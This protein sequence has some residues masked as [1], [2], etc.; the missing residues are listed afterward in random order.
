MNDK[1]TLLILLALLLG[2]FVILGAVLL[3]SNGSAISGQSGSSQIE[4]SSSSV[5]LI[6]KRPESIKTAA[7]KT[8]TQTY[9]LSRGGDGRLI[10]DGLNGLLQSE[11]ALNAA[12]S[13]MAFIQADEKIIDNAE[14]L[15][16]YGF[17]N[18][19]SFRIT[20]DDG[21]IFTFEAGGEAPLGGTY[22]RVN[23]ENTVYL[24]KDGVSGLFPDRESFVEKNLISD[25]TY[26]DENTGKIVV[27]N[28]E[29]IV[30]SGAIRENEIILSDNPDPDPDSGAF[31]SSHTIETYYDMPC[32][33][34]IMSEIMSSLLPFSADTA[35]FANPDED[36]LERYGLNR[37]RSV[38]MFEV[39]G[40]KH[41]IRLGNKNNDS[42]FCTV[43]DVPCLFLVNSI[44][45]PWAELSE[46]QLIGDPAF[47]PKETQI[48]NITFD[49]GSE[50]DVYALT[51]GKVGDENSVTA[52]RLNGKDCPVDNYKNI[53][54]A[55]LDALKP[56]QKGEA[57]YGE[58]RLLTVEY[59]YFAS[60]K[61]DVLDFYEADA[62]TCR[63]VINGQAEVFVSADRVKS[64]IS[65]IGIE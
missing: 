24:I 31:Y 29:N 37:P 22:V 61:I 13:A 44:N 60:D 64:V 23:G 7:V 30:L 38:I 34:N 15:S 56:V 35:V 63:L 59:G 48:S 58:R 5:T 14:N 36:I 41:T 45:V 21:E 27:V 25:P 19:R 3:I 46:Y 16:I 9:T 47:E 26:T 62:T 6:N 8:S 33:D 52:A 42:Y 2:L 12:A 20:F 32:D 1:K 18:V 65:L 51:I 54:Y 53:Y 43:D 55:L 39:Q 57:L 11:T 10:A 17:D 28:A 50:I 40:Q 4:V 49:S